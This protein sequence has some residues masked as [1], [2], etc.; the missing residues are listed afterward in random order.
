MPREQILDTQVKPL[1]PNAVLD[2]N[3]FFFPFQGANY[4]D[5]SG[6][7]YDK[8]DIAKAKS[9]L[10]ADG[11]TMSGGV[12]QKNGQK[13][14]FK[15]MHKINPR[16][17]AEEQLIAASCGQAGM[18]VV[19]DGDANWS[20]RLGAGQFDSVVFAWVGS[21]LQ[22]PNK[23]IFHTPPSKSNLLSNYGYYSNPQVDQY[24]DTLA[25]NPDPAA[26]ATAAN[27]ADVIM[28][29]D[30]PQIPLY[31]WPDIYS[32]NK[33]MSGFDYNPTQQGPTWNDQ[34]WSLAAS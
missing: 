23:A 12:Y 30:M 32:S 14:Q 21:A 26:Q 6:G 25:T 20:T 11:W 33:K 7:Q 28:W 22:S 27:A 15:L 3:R 24:M 17:S 8:V 5:N 29:K 2:E 1:L 19:D 18:K 34:S 31:Q 16:R 13:L 10:E 9:T 4:K